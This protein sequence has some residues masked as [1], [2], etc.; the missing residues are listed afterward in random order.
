MAVGTS[1][2]NDVFECPVPLTL[3]SSTR[4]WRLGIVNP[5]S[6]M[7][8]L[9]KETKVFLASRVSILYIHMSTK[10]L[11]FH[12]CFVLRTFQ[13]SQKVIFYDVF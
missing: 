1:C 5:N 9:A 8:L 13:V 4:I 12:R 7:Y 3:I 11:H 2:A 6:R 10:V